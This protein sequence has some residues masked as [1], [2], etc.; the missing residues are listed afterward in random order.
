MRSTFASDKSSFLEDQE[1]RELEESLRNQEYERIRIIK[2]QKNIAEVKATLLKNQLI[3][4]HH[5]VID[6]CSP[7]HFDNGNTLIQSWE[8]DKFANQEIIRLRSRAKIMQKKKEEQKK[9]KIEQRKKDL[10]KKEQDERFKNMKM[11]VRVSK[12][13]KSMSLRMSKMKKSINK[14]Q[15]IFETTESNA[16]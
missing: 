12:M 10:L 3:C 16:T 14:A 4:N 13:N 1:K 2:K 6:D 8:V 7:N 15:V 9:Q 5:K 11:S